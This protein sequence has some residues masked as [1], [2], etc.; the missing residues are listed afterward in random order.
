MASASVLDAL[1]VQLAV[2]REGT[3]ILLDFGTPILNDT[4]ASSEER[5][6][7]NEELRPPGLVD[8]PKHRRL[9]IVEPNV[10]YASVEETDVQI[11]ELYYHKFP[12]LAQREGYYIYGD[13]CFAILGNP[14]ENAAWN[15]TPLI[16]LQ[17]LA[18]DIGNNAYRLIIHPNTGDFRRVLFD[19]RRP[20]NCNQGFL[21]DQEHRNRLLLRPKRMIPE[22]QPL[23][24]ICHGILMSM[25]YPILRSSRYRRFYLSHDIV[26]DFYETL[27]ARQ[28][29]MGYPNYAFHED[30]WGTLFEDIC[31][32]DWTTSFDEQWVHLPLLAQL[33]WGTVPPAQ[34]EAIAR[35]QR[36]TY[37]EIDTTTDTCGICRTDFNKN[38]LVVQL[39]CGHIYC[40]GGCVEMWLHR[41]DSCPTCRRSLAPF[42]PER[43]N[44]EGV[45]EV[46]HDDE[47]VGLVTRDSCGRLDWCGDGITRV[48]MSAAEMVVVLG[49]QWS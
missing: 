14:T 45:Y 29:L 2:A 38:A 26:D 8:T 17:T 47:R 21:S 34:S 32:E 5:N 9:F 7:D 1:L 12:S 15:I 30:T 40:N 23:C 10:H 44:Q 22:Y 35:L 19:H 24:P 13:E 11:R 16:N 36:R 39:P 48:I 6:V 25:I 46:G 43:D 37:G 41:H 3:L 28:S 4:T 20:A 18:L 42:E 31:K 49:W 33:I 27:N